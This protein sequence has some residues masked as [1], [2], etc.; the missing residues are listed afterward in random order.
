MANEIESAQFDISIYTS[1]YVIPVL[2]KKWMVIF[3]FLAALIIALAVNFVVKPEFVSQGT[4]LVEEARYEYSRLKENLGL[5]RAAPKAYVSAEIERLKSDSFAAEVLKILSDTSRN[6]LRTTLNLGAQIIR[7]TV[8]L[9]KRRE[10]KKE[11]ETVE[12]ISALRKRIEIRGTPEIGLIWITARTINKEVAPVLVKSY[13]EVW[14]ALNLEENKK[15]VRAQREFANEQKGMVYRKFQEVEEEL[16]SFK[17]YYG[18][19]GELEIARDVELNLE[20]ERM[21]GKLGL[22]RERLQLMDRVYL[23]TRTKEAGVVG[24]IRV[25]DSPMIPGESSKRRKRI[26]LLIIIVGGLGFGIGITLLLDFIRG[27]IRHENDITDVVHVPIL[28]Y[29]PRL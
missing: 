19:P 11:A 24:N 18:L 7:G 3:C 29:I 10:S 17:K 27:P 4:L 16:I 22:A 14:L 28:G 25:I 23:E 21:M 2:E 12:L 8:N 6:E 9:L 5:Q 13:I 26:L 15:G 20:L 1:K